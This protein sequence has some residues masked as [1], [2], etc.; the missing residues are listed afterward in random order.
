MSE[1]EYKDAVAEQSVEIA[2]NTIDTLKKELEDK[3]IRLDEAFSLIDDKDTEIERQRL[4]MGDMEL[5]IDEL[6]KKPSEQLTKLQAQYD[7]KCEEVKEL[8]AIE[9]KRTQQNDFKPASSVILQS[10]SSKKKNEAW[11]AAPNLSGFVKALI[12]V[13]LKFDSYS[14]QRKVIF[15]LTDDGQLK[16]ARQGESG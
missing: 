11:I 15:D 3:E 14:S 1:S 8:R 13:S 2:L 6:Q 4:Q 10:S 12:S 7:L 16:N 5:R 9:G